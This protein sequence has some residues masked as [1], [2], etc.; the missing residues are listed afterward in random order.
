M[1][2]AII[3]GGNLGHLLGALYGGRHTSTIIT[4][5]ATKEIQYNVIQAYNDQGPTHESVVGF[6]SDYWYVCDADLIFVT[7]PSDMRRN[8]CEQMKS[9]VKPGAIVCAIPAVGNWFDIARHSFRRTGVKVEGLR[10]IPFI[11]DKCEFGKR[12]RFV[13]KKDSIYAPSQTQAEFY[14]DFFDIP[15]GVVSELDI[16]LT[17]ANPI[18]HPGNLYGMFRAGEYTHIPSKP[19]F[20]EELTELGAA[21]IEALDSDIGKIRKKAGL[22]PFTIFDWFEQ[23]YGSSID[24]KSNLLTTFRTNKCYK[25]CVAP[26]EETPDGFTLIANHRVFKEDIP[27]GLELLKAKALKYGV[28][29]PTIDVVLSWAHS[30]MKKEDS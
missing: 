20:Y 17:P 25:G 13:G 27:F 14:E 30:I 7:V 24:D 28:E 11:C 1:N 3:G 8:A 23:N 26:L 10:D 6:S 29:T 19:L 9:F 2:I 12:V 21:T 4:S 15:C 16:L 22:A 18:I 5:K